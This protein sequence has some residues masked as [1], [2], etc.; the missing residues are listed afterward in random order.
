MFSRQLRGSTARAE[1]FLRS[2][3][4]LLLAISL[5]PCVVIG[6]LRIET[7]IENV[8]Q[9]LPD[10]SDERR[11]YDWFV[12]HFGADDV[13]IVSWPGATFSDPRVEKLAETIR[14]QDE[15]GYVQEVS[16]GPGLVKRLTSPPFQFSLEEARQRLTGLFIGKD[17]RTTCLLIRFTERGQRHRLET[18]DLVFSAMRNVGLPRDRLRLAGAP[19][20]AMR[21]D[22]H[23]KFSLLWMTIPSILISTFLAWICLRDMRLVGL[24]FLVAS[25]AA[26]VGTAIVPLTGGEFDVVLAALPTLIYVVTIS[27]AVHLINYYRMDACSTHLPDRKST[28]QR[29][30]RLGWKP[31]CLSACST[32]LGLGA[33]MTSGFP[34]IRG[35]GGYAAV[36]VMVSL[37]VLLIYLPPGLAVA[38]APGDSR[39]REGRVMALSRLRELV[40]AAVTRY[41]KVVL[42]V[43][44]VM[45]IGAG[46]LLPSLQSSLNLEHEF[47]A[48]S[49]YMQNTRWIE[50]HLGPT[51][52]TE[53]ILRIPLAE[54]PEFAKRLKAVRKVQRAL[55]ELP[56]IAATDSATDFIPHPPTGGGIRA[57][58]KRVM[59]RQKLDDMRGSMLESPYLAVAENEEL[60][61]ITTRLFVLEDINHAALGT[62]V[63]KT[64]RQSL[65]QTNLPRSEI[66]YTGVS[67]V[68]HDG[69]AR[70]MEELLWS[71]SMAF[72][73]VMPVMVIALGHLGAGLLA[74]LP[75][76]LPALVVFGGMSLFG[77]ALQPGVVA[78][79]SLALGIAVDDTCHF[80]LRYRD[81][82]LTHPSHKH[83]LSSAYEVCSTAMLQTTLISGLGLLVFTASPL[84]SLQLFATTIS[85]LM[86]VALAC[87]LLVLPALLSAR[88]G[89]VF[90]RDRSDPVGNC[91]LS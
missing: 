15:A 58:I 90:W 27:G 31:C 35:F 78:T 80:L 64:V 68:Y 12:E 86:A 5:I 88:I 47:S 22:A 46:F 43:S 54:A 36:G 40:L 76:I 69:Q 57:V 3:L 33:L 38:V 79:A 34:V 77:V 18:M 2:R 48:E 24:L 83:A 89:R 41:R 74:M 73:L 67:H 70:L 13:V 63:R 49:R 61:R 19:F 59:Y 72:A 10:A 85:L 51:E 4:R 81:L 8:Y 52:M 20:L 11:Q 65:A 45:A 30:L 55:R 82:Q 71:Y 66:V 16:T 42:S 6:L 14:E 7:N 25:S 75:N 37:A 9:W 29:I 53:T 60:W 23:V 1:V 50:E 26:A 91:D 56:E 39:V 84:R 17:G 87:D 44:V 32:A 62:Q 21:F 28:A